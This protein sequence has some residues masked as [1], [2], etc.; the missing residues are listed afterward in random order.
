MTFVVEFVRYV[1]GHAVALDSM[2]KMEV[3]RILRTYYH[4]FIMYN[5]L[6]WQ[7]SEFQ[8]GYI[9]C[10]SNEYDNQNAVIVGECVD[11]FWLL[12]IF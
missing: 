6:S 4:Y 12:F 11:M 2:Y 9:W 8:Y 7:C 10:H 5:Q 1:D 3:Q